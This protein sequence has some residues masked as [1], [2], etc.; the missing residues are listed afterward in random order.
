M[1]VQRAAPTSANFILLKRFLSTERS[2]S[3]RA[4][5]GQFLFNALRS[6]GMSKKWCKQAVLSQSVTAATSESSEEMS[7]WFTAPRGRSEFLS[8]WLHARWSSPALCHVPPLSAGL[9]VLWRNIT[10]QIFQH[11]WKVWLKEIWSLKQIS[12]FQKGTEL[13]RTAT[14]QYSPIM[15]GSYILSLVILISFIFIMLLV[16]PASFFQT[17][18]LFCATAPTALCWKPLNFSERCWCSFSFSRYS[19]YLFL[20][21]T[22]HVMQQHPPR[23]YVRMSIIIQLIFQDIVC[24]ETRRT[25]SNNFTSMLHRHEHLSCFFPRMQFDSET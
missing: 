11:A 13:S 25:Y 15:S 7:R 24:I 3:K 19:P 16:L 4:S 9:G 8:V 18:C 20:S 6:W 23:S 1:D 21:P 12:T 5:P 2:D 10:S 14:Q 17:L 22:N